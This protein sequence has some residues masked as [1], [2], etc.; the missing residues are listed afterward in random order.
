MFS[1]CILRLSFL[2]LFRVLGDHG[3]VLL[4]ISENSR[5]VLKIGT[6]E[7]THPGTG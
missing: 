2:G 5:N 7:E 6:S 3:E 4:K 1:E